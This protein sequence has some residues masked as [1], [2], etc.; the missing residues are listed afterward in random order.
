MAAVAVGPRAIIVFV[1]SVAVASSEDETWAQAQAL[2]MWALTAA[3]KEILETKND[4]GLKVL[5]ITTNHEYTQPQGLPAL[6]Q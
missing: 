3:V 4:L 5:V 1:S 6:L 2:F